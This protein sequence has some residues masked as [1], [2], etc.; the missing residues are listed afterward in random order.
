MLITYA[1]TYMLWKLNMWGGGDVK[2][3]TAIATV[4][5]SGLNINFLNIFLIPK[6]RLLLKLRQILEKRFYTEVKIFRKMQ[7][8]FLH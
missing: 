7:F 8:Y 3:F 4:I 5:P 2:L 6:Q 1:I